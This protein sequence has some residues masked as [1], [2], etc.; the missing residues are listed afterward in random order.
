LKKLVADSFL[1]GFSQKEKVKTKTYQP[2]KKKDQGRKRPIFKSEVVK[3]GL[4]LPISRM[5]I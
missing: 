4:K 1:P 2:E 3:K 5:R